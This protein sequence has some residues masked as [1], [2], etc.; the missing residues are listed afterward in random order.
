MSGNGKVD[1]IV[2]GGGHNGLITAGYLARA[3][4]KVTV[5]ERRPIVGG[6]CVTEEII[7]GFRASRT[8]YACSLLMPEIVRDFRMKEQGFRVYIPDPSG[9]IPFPDGRYL[10]SHSDTARYE[11]EVAKFS[12][13]DFAALEQF[14]ADLSRLRPL[15]EEILRTTPPKFP[16]S[17]IKDYWSFLKLARKVKSLDRR[18]LRFFMELMTASCAEILDRRFESTEI[19]AT[20]AHQ[21]TI[22]ACVGVMSPGSAYVML[23]DSIGGVDGQAGAWGFVYGGMGT[24]TEILATTCRSRGVEIRTGAAVD[25]VLVKNGRAQ[26]VVLKNGDELRSR[27]VVSNTDPKRTFLDLVEEQHLEADFLE[28]IRNF[29]IEGSSIKVNCALAELP[30]WTCLPGQDPK[31]PQHQAMI[32]IG[33]SMEYLERA[34]DDM[35]YGRPS[36]RPF[37]E[38]TI[39]STVDD[40]LAPEGKHVLSLFV[41]YGPYHLREGTWPE[42]RE[43]V[44][45]NIIDTL[46]E[47]APNIKSCIIAREVLSPWDLEQEFGL[48]G[49]QIFHGE[50]SQ[51]QLFCMRPAWGWADYRTPIRGLYLCG[52][53]AH[54]G[55]GVLGGPGMNAS[56]EILRDLR[57]G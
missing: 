44:G 23:H 11:Q 35:K 37:I 29:K 50:I 34:F 17:R 45:D 49:G 46:A 15:I 47:Y 39:A 57:R 56:R 3:G 30:N 42:I 36:R 18:D 48:T 26:G 5:L 9:F 31:A 20:L 10:L 14:D 2:V 41:Q 32:G 53:G 51:D 19:K 1:V 8:S 25:R 24:I 7:P 12:T 16:P 13:R 21:G 27:I 55:G 4:L 38:G 28:E 6:A 54:P 22:G 40:S 52:S 33:P 43:K